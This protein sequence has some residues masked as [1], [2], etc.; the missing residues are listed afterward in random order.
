VLLIKNRTF[1]VKSEE[2]LLDI[3]V[4]FKNSEVQNRHNTSF[5][6]SNVYPLSLNATTR[7][8]CFSSYAIFMYRVFFTILKLNDYTIFHPFIQCIAKTLSVNHALV[9]SFLRILPSA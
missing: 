5:N 1:Q 4:Q 8:L 7:T 9:I 6:S 2:E 3:V